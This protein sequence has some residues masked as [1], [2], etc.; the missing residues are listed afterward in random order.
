MIFSI[1]NRKT[2]FSLWNEHVNNNSKL[3][4]GMRTEERERKRHRE[5]KKQTDRDREKE[6]NVMW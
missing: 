1:I 5:T 6:S 4:E 2:F 3:V